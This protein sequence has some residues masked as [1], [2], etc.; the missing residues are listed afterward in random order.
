MGNG[1]GI[2]EKLRRIWTPDRE[3][4]ELFADLSPQSALDSEIRDY[5]SRIMFLHKQITLDISDP[6]PEFNIRW[7]VI[8]TPPPNPRRQVSI[9]IELSG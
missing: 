3:V 5:F 1:V 6:V 8:H 9:W 2:V 7:N 4:E